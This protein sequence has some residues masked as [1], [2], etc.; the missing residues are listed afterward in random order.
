MS[1]AREAG[2]REVFDD[3]S[4]STHGREYRMATEVASRTAVRVT[5][6]GAVDELA[7][8][9]HEHVK[10]LLQRSIAHFHVTD[11]QHLLSL[12]NEAG[13]EL[14]DESTLE[15]AGVKPG[16]LLILRPSEV[17]GG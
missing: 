9:P 12:F 4:R 6:N 8:Q 3:A 2:A 15:D 17:K 1:P 13:Q 5:Y 11:N 7:Y 14:P 10:A 16:D